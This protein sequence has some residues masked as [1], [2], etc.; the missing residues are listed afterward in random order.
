MT[1]GSVLSDYQDHDPIT[2]IE[3]RE[4]ESAKKSDSPTKKSQPSLLDG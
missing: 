3:E 2:I 4:A 1:Q